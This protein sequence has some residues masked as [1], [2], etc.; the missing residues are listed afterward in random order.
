VIYYLGDY[1]AF[2]DK[3]G[4]GTFVGLRTPAK[5]G[6]ALCYCT[7]SLAQERDMWSARK[8]IYDPLRLNIKGG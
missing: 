5:T 4:G 2:S 6:S 7:Q 3:C 1:V 8:I